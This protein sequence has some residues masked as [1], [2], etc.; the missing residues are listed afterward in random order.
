MGK[1]E[2]AIGVSESLLGNIEDLMI[3]GYSG[4]LNFERDFISE[5]L[6]MIS[7]FTVP[8]TVKFDKAGEQI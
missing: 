7:G 2:N 5:G 1:D 3:K 4:N 6:D 8:D